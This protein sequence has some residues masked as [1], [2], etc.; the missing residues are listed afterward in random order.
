MTCDSE[1]KRSS[2]R[3]YVCVCMYECTVYLVKST[4]YEAR[5][6]AVFFNLLSL[7][8]S[9]VQI[10]SSAPCSQTPSVYA[11]PLMSETKFHTPT[12]P[13]AKLL[14]VGSHCYHGMARPQ[15]ADGGDDLQI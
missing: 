11:S 2:C 14:F 7:D 3:L 8:L 9:L 12:E 5:H 1:F 4:S 10:V 15:A 6:Y 13:L